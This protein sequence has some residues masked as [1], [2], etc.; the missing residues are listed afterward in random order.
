MT[1]YVEDTD[2]K[3]A[4]AYTDKLFEDTSGLSFVDKLITR[5]NSK[6]K[7]L[8]IGSGPGQFAKHLHKKNF[9]IESI[10]SCEEMLAVA[11]TKVPKTSFTKMDMRQLSFQIKSLTAF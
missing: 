4:Q 7:I 1:K 5:P 2:A 9:V 10:D 11:K 8:G 3:I 6:A